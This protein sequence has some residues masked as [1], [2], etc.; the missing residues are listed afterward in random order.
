MGNVALI[1]PRP[2]NISLRE[3]LPTLVGATY[4]FSHITNLTT[5]L[6]LS[7]FNTKKTLAPL[8]LRR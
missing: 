6:T 8:D 3:R 1:V 5:F 4:Q 2:T 7:T